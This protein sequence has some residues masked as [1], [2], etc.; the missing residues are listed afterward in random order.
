MSSFCDMS[1]KC[2]Q[3]ARI[4]RPYDDSIILLYCLNKHCTHQRISFK[5]HLLRCNTN[6]SKI[7]ECCWVIAVGIKRFCDVNVVFLQ[8]FTHRSS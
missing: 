2:Q 4:T 8:K 6:F 1:Q 3:R 5:Y 7:A